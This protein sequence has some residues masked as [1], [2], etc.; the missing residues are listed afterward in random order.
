MIIDLNADDWLDIYEG[1]KVIVNLNANA[2]KVDPSFIIGIQAILEILRGK[3]NNG[4]I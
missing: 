3:R 2:H 4:G 1:M